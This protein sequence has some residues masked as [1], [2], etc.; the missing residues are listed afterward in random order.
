MA[1]KAADQ[2]FVSQWNQATAWAQAN[3][4]P[5][6]TLAPVY[7]YDLGRLQ[8]GDFPMSQAE[9][10]RAILAAANP[11]NVTPV[12]ADKPQP[13]N[14]FG[15]ARRDLGMIFTG[16][17][18]QHLV[19]NLWDTTKN[20]VEDVLD[21]KRLQGKDPGETVANVLQNTLASFVPGAYDIGTILK[22]DPTLSGTE[23][24]KALMQDP[25]IAVLDL[26]PVDAGGAFTKLFARTDTGA[27]VAAHLGMS[28]DELAG[29]SIHKLMSQVPTGVTKVTPGGGALKN[30]TVGE[31]LSTRLQ[32]SPLGT[33]KAVQTLSKTFEVGSQHFSSIKQTLLTPFMDAASDLDDAQ[34]TQMTDIISKNQVGGQNLQT[35]LDAPGVDPA[36]KKAIRDFFQG[37][38][39]FIREEA[40]AAGDVAPVRRLD[41]SVGMYTATQHSDVLNARDALKKTHQAL[42]EE[43]E[44]DDPLLEAATK[45]KAVMP[46]LGGI[47]DQ[48]NADARKVTETNPDLLENATEKYR[49]P[50]AKKDEVRNYG[51]KRSLARRLFGT[52]GLVDT[53]TKAIKDGDDDRVGELAAVLESRLTAWGSR[54]V[55]ASADPAF[56]AVLKGVQMVKQAVKERNRVTDALNRRIEGDASRTEYETTQMREQRAS[57]LADQKASQATDR[58]NQVSARRRE[59]DMV[60]TGLKIKLDHYDRVLAQMTE[61]AL[62]KGDNETGGASMAFHWVGDQMR[63]GPGFRVTKA[64]ADEVYA[65]V[66]REI[67]GMKMT[68]DDLTRQ[69]KREAEAATKAAKERWASTKKQMSKMHQAERAQLLDHHD[70]QR[71]IDGELTRKVRGYLKTLRDFHRAVY[72]NPTDNW[73]DMRYQVYTQH[74]IDGLHNAELIEAT[75]KRL[76][77]PQERIDEIK[78]DP[79]RLREA[80]KVTVDDVFDNPANWNPELVE[81]ASIAAKAAERSAIDEVNK[82]RVEGWEPEWIPAVNPKDRPSMGVRANLGTDHVDV[83]FRRSNQMV[84]TRYDLEA[85]AS[86]GLTQALR[87]DA[88][89][90]L[91]D[92]IAPQV[93]TGTQLRDQMDAM[94]VLEGFDPTAEHLEHAYAKK[95]EALGLTE[96]NPIE[97]FKVNMPRW[98][99]ERLFLPTGIKK[100]L[101][102]MM[103]MQAKTGLGVYDKATDLFRFSILGLSP[104]YTAH[105][106]AGGMMMLALR[107]TPYMPSMLMKAYRAMKD[108]TIPLDTFTHPSEE[109]YSRLA[110][111][112][113]EHARASGK[114]GAFLALQEHIG[115]VQ[116]VALSKASPVH[117][118]KAA[119]DLNMRHTRFM[120]NLYRATAYLDYAA[121]AERRGTFT[122]ELTGEE[123]QMTKERAMAEGQQHA[124]D[125]FGDMR[126]MSPMERQFMPKVFPFWGWTRHILSYV[127]SYPVDHPW[128]AMIL[129]LMAYEN[130]ADVPKGLPE[131]LQFLFFFGSPNAQGNVT[132]VDTRFLDPFRDT[133]NYASLGGWL[134]G[135]N[136]APLA[137]LSMTDPSIVYGSN[138]L[139]PNLSY[140]QFYGIQTAGTQGTPLTGLEQFIP[141]AGVLPI[142]GDAMA[143]AVKKA[144]SWRQLAGSNPNEFYKHIFEDLNIP[145]AQIQKINVK[146][147]A[148]QDEVARYDVAKAAA[149]NAFSTGNFALLNGYSSVPNPLNDDYEVTPQQLEAVYQAAMTA[150]PGL[151]PEETVTPPPTPAGI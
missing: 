55:D 10:T 122:D 30:L 59:I 45:I 71:E 144:G 40:V 125:V 141:Q 86:K 115:T 37:P 24:F 92:D 128:R 79:Q 146:Q 76:N 14:V 8:N 143:D 68:R 137:L 150:Y 39:R 9:R 108:G 148:A 105:I 126:L 1:K 73:R 41:G 129:S 80:V 4:I 135:L 89:I 5:T 12:P 140:D 94:G 116:K 48:A 103:D 104:R 65:R 134:E 66:R 17:E 25:L 118:L 20:T 78:Q 100:A 2:E 106:D 63:P 32:D 56:Q 47:I 18:P 62:T 53:L 70:A 101:D 110:R 133:A 74:L 72:D 36:V 64:A 82:L 6:N 109:G 28:T 13:T 34:K 117:W 43:M 136:P 44:E 3:D 33:S 87:R 23:G 98:E 54:S 60:D 58:A 49:P 11:N 142:I 52:D 75:E 124:I 50:G 99:G 29:S 149:E 81:H 107:S 77:I 111:A 61:A 96:F 26:L 114:Q 102:K 19:T 112:T 147:I 22:A 95:L 69:A 145:F 67:R 127:S 131:R 51:Q 121:K 16:L 88:N 46:K 31:W 42:Q 139:Y 83:A 84:N 151:P 97:K 57:E 93:M 38:G 120:N 15:N 132:A 91:L 7:Q 90:Q 138:Q 130:S 27:A 21:P 113:Q 85:A 35:L 119:A 123:V